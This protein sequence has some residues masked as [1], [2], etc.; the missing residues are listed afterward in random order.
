MV[1]EKTVITVTDRMR[2]Q[3]MIRTL[4]TVGD[5]YRSHLRELIEELCHAEVVPATEVASDVI[6][7]NSR[8]RTRDLDFGVTQTF[9]LVYHGDSGMF[10]SRLSVLTPLGIRLLG[11]RVADVVE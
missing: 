9:T 3:E 11:C 2:L 4:Q 8:V 1:K 6:T 7:M 5:P 10:D